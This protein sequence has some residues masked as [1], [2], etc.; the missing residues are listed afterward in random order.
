MDGRAAAH[1]RRGP[2]R[3]ASRGSTARCSTST[4]P[5]R[6]A[7]TGCA[8]C[9]SWRPT[10]RCSCS[11]GS[12][13]SAAASRRSR[14]GAQDYLVKG[15]DGGGAAPLAPLRGRAPP[16]GA[17]PAA[18]LDRRSS[19]RARTPGWS[20]GCCPR[21]WSATPRWRSPRTTARPPP[22]AARRRL[23]RRGAGRPTGAV[24]AVIGDVSGHGPDE[25]ALGVCLR[26][27]WR[28]LVL[29]GVPPDDVLPPRLQEVLVHERHAEPRLH[30][31]VHGDRRARPRAA[32]VRLAGPPAAAAARRAGRRGAGPGAPAAARRA[33]RRDLAAADVALPPAWSLLLYTDGV[34]EGRVPAARRRL[35]EEGSPTLSR[36]PRSPPGATSR[37]ARAGSSSS[38]P[39]SSTAARWPTTSRCC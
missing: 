10:S 38:A 36:T 7:S 19:R 9:A 6:R 16:G 24:H 4:C 37:R 31:A 17:A 15:L 29:A 23:L 35:G 22:R 26:I 21:R 30:H 12:T 33:R 25:A 1:A 20:A 27:A 32:P 39:R 2:R 3:R 18:A 14:P 13:T 34:I 28:T 11:P 8:S 5:T